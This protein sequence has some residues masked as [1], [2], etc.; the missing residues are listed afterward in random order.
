VFI[1][2]SFLDKQAMAKSKESDGK[3]VAELRT[4]KRMS[5]G[6]D[7]NEKKKLKRIEMEKR[8]VRS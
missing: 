5:D 2:I 7:E 6:W 1:C 3:S 8:C 4:A